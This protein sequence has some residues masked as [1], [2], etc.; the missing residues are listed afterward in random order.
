MDDSVLIARAR[1][2]LHWRQLS[3][4]CTASEVSAALETVSGNVFVGV[5]I[6]AACGIGACAEY[7]AVAQMVTAGE[8]QIRKIVAVASDGKI[9]PPCGRCRELLYQVDRRNI[10]TQVI[11]AGGRLVSLSTLLPEPWQNSWSERSTR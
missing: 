4:D 1:E 7:G 9:I 2:V 6:S 3:D 5:S 11:L 8:S 10:R